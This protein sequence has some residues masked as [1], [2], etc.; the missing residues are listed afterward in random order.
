VMAAAEVP[1]VDQEVRTRNVP[2]ISHRAPA[3]AGRP[4]CL[5]QSHTSAL[6]C[7]SREQRGVTVTY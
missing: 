4:N 5:G 2:C 3:Q 7:D 1:G 6:V